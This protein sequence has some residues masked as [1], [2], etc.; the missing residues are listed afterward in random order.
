[1]VSVRLGQAKRT[2]LGV[3]ALSGAIAIGA[4]SQLQAADLNPY[5]YKD[6]SN[7][8]YSDPRYA[9]LYGPDD[10]YD[11]RRRHDQYRGRHAKIEREHHYKAPVD[12]TERYSEQRHYRS[13]HRY[14]NNRYDRHDRPHTRRWR[15]R[16]ALAPH[17]VP[18]RVVM[19][20]LFR[21]G[22]HDFHGL[23]LRGEKAYVKAQSEDGRLFNLTIARC[24][25]E[26]IAARQVEYRHTNGR[27]DRRSYSEV[28]YRHRSYK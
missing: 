12:R 16:Y 27:Y 26:I 2:I 18:R 6:K 21:D 1:M 4:I 24:S 13:D 10:R 15:G 25:G 5:A 17:C 8:P 23:D 22:W 3:L 20:R 19:R 11:A 28:P 7:S 14:R 9:E